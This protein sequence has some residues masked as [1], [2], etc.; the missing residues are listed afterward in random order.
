MIVKFNGRFVEGIYDRARINSNVYEL[1]NGYFLIEFNGKQYI[2]HMSCSLVA[3]YSNLNVNNCKK[4]V[5]VGSE[6]SD[7]DNLL[8]F[9]NGQDKVQD[10]KGGVVINVSD[11]VLVKLQL[12]NCYRDQKLEVYV[13]TDFVE[14]DDYLITRSNS[15]LIN[16]ETGE[17]IK[18]EYSPSDEVV[19]RAIEVNKVYILEKLC[20]LCNKITCLGRYDLT[21]NLTKQD[22][23]IF[24]KLC[25]ELEKYDV[26]ESV[27]V[28]Q[29]IAELNLRRAMALVDQVNEDEWLVKFK[30]NFMIRLRHGI[31]SILHKGFH[32]IYVFGVRGMEKSICS[33]AS[34]VE[35]VIIN[36]CKC[37]S[38]CRKLKDCE[39]KL[40]A[41]LIKSIGLDKIQLD[42]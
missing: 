41:M 40:W 38:L 11:N 19:E 34:E 28:G 10:Y 2:Q 17:I 32:S 27:L 6:Y 37:Y 36:L 9:W 20:R 14:K 4:L 23:Q 16:K 35:E 21:Y 42:E 31:V 3:V 13:N 25:K 15:I 12:L 30:G 5:Y 39:L 7:G 18:L 29:S 8:Y 33:S 1:A 24:D 26:Q 22:K